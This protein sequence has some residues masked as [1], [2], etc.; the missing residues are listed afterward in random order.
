[1]NYYHLFPISPNPA[2]A[3]PDWFAE[4]RGSFLCKGCGSVPRGSNV[5]DVAVQR[6]PDKS[7]IN[8]I[9][10]LGLCFAVTPLL[11]TLSNGATAS[12]FHLGRVLDSHRSQIAA[13]HTFM[14]P[15]NVLVRGNEKS[16]FRICP[17]CGRVL[18]SAVGKRYVLKREVEGVFIAEDQMG[19]LVVNESVAQRCY[20]GKWKNLG[21]KQLEIRDEPVDG[22]DVPA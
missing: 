6:V 2:S 17:Q 12:V 21:F 16:T 22:L 5:V 13:V 11:D 1:M 4:A 7:S 18:Y 3:E 10:G 15:N 20:A 9:Y 8:V 19:C 14:C